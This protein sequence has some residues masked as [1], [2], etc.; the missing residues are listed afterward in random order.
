MIGAGQAYNSQRQAKKAASEQ[1]Q[2]QKR[3][4]K[5]A[6]DQKVQADLNRQRDQQRL[7][8]KAMMGLA[9][10]QRGGTLL[11]GPQGLGGPAAK[12]QLGT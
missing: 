5:G 8:Q 7:R 9:P 2:A 12:T 11:T 4:E 1:G 10:S 6:N 3:L